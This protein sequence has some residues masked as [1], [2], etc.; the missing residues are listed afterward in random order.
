MT[1]INHGKGRLAKFI[2]V[3]PQSRADVIKLQCKAESHAIRP[4]GLG[5]SQ[6]IS[7]IRKRSPGEPHAGGE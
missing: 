5:W 1:L 7:M 2:V 4:Q 3:R 6:V